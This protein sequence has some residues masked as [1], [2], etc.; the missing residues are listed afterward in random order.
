VFVDS[1]VGHICPRSRSAKEVSTSKRPS[2]PLQRYSYI[3]IERNS[4]AP[5]GGRDGGGTARPHGPRPTAVVRPDPR[6]QDYARLLSS[7]P[8]LVNGPAEPLVEDS[9][10]LV[11][12][13]ASHRE[14]D[15]R[16]VDVGSGGGMPGLPLKLALP[17]LR[18]TLV[19]ADRR[20]A[21]FLT[22][23]AA[24]LHLDVEIV[25]ERAETAARGGLREAF[26]VATC[27]ALAAPAVALELCLPFVRPG[28]RLLA[29][30]T[31]DEAT[32]GQLVKTAAILGGGEPL[33]YPAPSPA[34]H[35]GTVLV[36]PKISPT[37]AAYPRRPGIP[38]RRPLGA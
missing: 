26:D 25:P 1:Q 36:V 23:A 21:A 22:A 37:P 9:L 5:E 38:N 3:G 20:K 4:R 28:G 27:R 30:R 33:S 10:V 11:P 7:W 13:L 17:A 6:F 32:D 31:G 29:M 15:L 35:N 19:E 8:G 14:Q 12:H 16:L 24:R 18:V 34:R 2:H